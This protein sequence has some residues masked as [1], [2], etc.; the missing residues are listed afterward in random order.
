MPQV[1]VVEQ[2]TV[3]AQEVLE[4]VATLAALVALDTATLPQATAPSTQDLVVAVLDL[5]MIT[6]AAVVTQ[7]QAV[8]ASLFFN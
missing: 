3:E 2:A 4:A 5:P 6:T 7:V 8:Q 1:V